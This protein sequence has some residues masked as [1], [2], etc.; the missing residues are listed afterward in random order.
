MADPAAS[1]AKSWFPLWLRIA[2]SVILGA[3]VGAIWRLEP[4]VFGISADHLGRLG[5]LVIRVIKALAVPLVLFS[6]LDAIVQFGF[7]G[8]RARTLLRVCAVN[9]SVA[10]AIGLTLMNVFEPGRRL[11]EY[12]SEHAPLAAAAETLKVEPLDPMKGLEQIVP[13]SVVQPF[14]ENNVIGAVLI[15]VL[16]GLALRRLKDAMHA[17]ATV[18]VFVTT[19]SAALQQ[20]LMWIVLAVPFAAFGLVAQ[21]V[22]RSGL[23]VFVGLWPYVVVILSGMAIHAF[24]YYR[25]SRSSSGRR[26]HVCISAAAPTRSSRGSRRTAAW[27]RSRSRSAA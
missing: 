9:V 27:R 5:M 3:T 11:R 2:L 8:R 7:T 17:T 26:R 19:I 16:L 6:I 15:A 25:S 13:T 21:S 22:G 20:G 18:E 1:E 12:L 10:F 4:I 14:S 23:G 24:V